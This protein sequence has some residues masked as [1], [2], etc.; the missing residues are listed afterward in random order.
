M[1]FSCHFNTMYAHIFLIGF[2][3]SDKV[4]KSINNSKTLSIL[5][6]FELF[7]LMDCELLCNKYIL[8]SRFN[9]FTFGEI[10]LPKIPKY[11]YY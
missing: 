9:D 4:D 11:T 3:S 7:T 1:Q 8:S 6:I 10:L 2:S 5:T